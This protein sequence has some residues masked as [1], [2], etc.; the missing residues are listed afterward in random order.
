MGL[1]GVPKKFLKKS[2]VLVINCFK[3]VYDLFFQK[4]HPPNINDQYFN[5]IKY[6]EPQSNELIELQHITQFFFLSSNN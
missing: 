6:Y 4:N 1:S 3:S 2:Q 5:F